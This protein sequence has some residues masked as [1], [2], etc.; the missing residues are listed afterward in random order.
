[1]AR[2]PV[3]NLVSGIGPAFH[4]LGFDPFIAKISFLEDMVIKRL[5]IITSSKEVGIEYKR[6]L[7]H[8]FLDSVEISSYSFEADEVDVI[9]EDTDTLLISTYSQYEVV[10][11][12][13]DRRWNVIICKLTLSKKSS[14]LLRDLNRDEPAMLVNLSYEMCIETIAL[15][16]QLGFDYLK[17]VPVYPGMDDVPLLHHAITSGESR[18]VPSFVPHTVDIGHRLI[19]KNTIVELAA[20]LNLEHIL[21]EKRVSDYFNKLVPY[22]KGVDFLISESLEVKNQFDTLLSIMQKGVIGINRKGVIESCND[23]A[24]QVLEANG[25]FLGYSIKEVL[26]Q[27][28][29]DQLP[30]NEVIQNKLI[31]VNNSYVTASVFP[32]KGLKKYEVLD[33]LSSA[34]VIIESFESQEDTQNKIRLQLNTKGHIARYSVDDIIGES[35]Q[36]KEVKELIIRMGNSHSAVL[37]TGESGTGKELVAQAIHNASP[38][39]DKHFVAI[40]CAAISASLL[41]SELFG[42]ERGA[43]TG[44]LKDGKMG[45][46]ELA[47]NGTLFL[48][49]IAEMPMELQARL[50]RV[51]QEKEVMRVGGDRVI[52]INVRIVAATNRN[53]I[54][55]IRNNSFREDLYYRLNVLP[56]NIFP[57]R[58]RAEDIECLIHSIIRRQGYRF[59]ISEDTMRFMN[60]YYWKGNVRELVNCLE[61]FANI[62]VHVIENSHL[63]YY[64]KDTAREAFV[65]ES[66]EISK[67]VSD[68]LDEKQRFVMRLFY[69]A[70]RNR[71]K[72]GRRSISDKAFQSDFHMTENDVRSILLQLKALGYIHIGKGRCGSVISQSGIE[73]FR[74]AGHS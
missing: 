8:I 54:E 33:V 15:L 41:E 35:R 50:L 45:I 30:L 38:V 73:I 67:V 37:I 17:L 42:Y 74:E 58:K 34:Y 44:A 66:V 20:S 64:M 61:Y 28:Q 9:K 39:K 71:K 29:V 2:I 21:T 22:N 68:R 10:K 69:D 12:F 65:R 48:D 32:V 27:L 23:M 62:G 47:N 18:H 13:L 3:Y 7:S 55:Q 11:K 43:F 1:M 31:K 6:Q 59:H 19:N 14:E 56:I 46:F 51:I 26:P 5:G 25:S 57:L 53:L 49:E 24:K 63:P 60:S 36:M 4:C 16:Y 70:H 72:L 52:K 40:N